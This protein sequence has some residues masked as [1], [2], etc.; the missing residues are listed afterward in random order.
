[1]S[2][3]N[4]LGAVL[5]SLNSEFGSGTISDSIYHQ[6]MHE[7]NGEI[8]AK[9]DSIDEYRNSITEYKSLITEAQLELSRWRP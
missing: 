1:M 3:I 6:R 8:F 7:V 9:M 5:D 4:G 2:D